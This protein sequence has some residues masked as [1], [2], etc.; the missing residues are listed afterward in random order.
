MFTTEDD[1]TSGPIVPAGL[2]LAPIGRRALGLLLDQI[3]VVVPVF[4]GFLAFGFNP[5]E[6]VTDTRAVWF[7]VATTSLSLIYETVA[8]WRWQRTLG[9]LATGTVVVSIVDGGPIGFTRSVQRSLVPTTVSAIPQVGMFLGIGVYALAL[10]H[11]L[12]Q[13]LHDRAAG[14]LVVRARHKAHGQP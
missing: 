10:F 9:K 1:E 12:R 11:P 4:G 5:K 8:V 7:V 14:S 3:L 13:G 2:H 6:A